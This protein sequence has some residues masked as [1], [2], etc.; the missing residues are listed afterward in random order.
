MRNLAEKT[1]KRIESLYYVKLIKRVGNSITNKTKHIEEFIG[2]DKK[3]KSIIYKNKEYG[4]T[5]GKVLKNKLETLVYIHPRVIKNL[6]E[7]NPF[8]SLNKRNIPDFLVFAEEIDHW[9]YLNAKFE[10]EKMPLNFELELQAAVTK[11]WLAA[12]SILNKGKSATKFMSDYKDKL[13]KDS[14]NFLMINIFPQSY[15]TL[16]KN[17]INIGGIIKGEDYLVADL[18]ARDYCKNL[19]VKS[20]DIIL[21]N[22][23]RF[24][25]MD[26]EEKINYVMR[27]LKT[28]PTL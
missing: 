13:N 15:L 25:W 17:K 28:N 14:L 1:Q 10:L 11:Y 23:S 5:H 20:I 18:L 6:K 12:W 27:D 7:N 3:T 2:E 9:V 4:S 22:L 26:G 8:K 19:T 16:D 24:Y 21:F